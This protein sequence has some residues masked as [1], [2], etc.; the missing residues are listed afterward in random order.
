MRAYGGDEAKLLLE[1]Y[2]DKC[3]WE[4][5]VTSC[6]WR[7]L[8][9]ISEKMLSQ[10][11][12]SDS[13]TR[14]QRGAGFILGETQDSAGQSPKLPTQVE[15]ALSGELDQMTNTSLLQAKLFY[16]FVILNFFAILAIC[17]SL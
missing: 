16:D 8:Y 4:G 10:L 7:N 14:A 6:N 3:T 13:E 5:K 2:S 12:W 17:I 15:S 11:W 1:M 9:Q